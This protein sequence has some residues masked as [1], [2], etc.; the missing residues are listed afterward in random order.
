MDRTLETLLPNSP[1]T[2]EQKHSLE[3]ILDAAA[4]WQAGTCSTGA[5]LE[6]G[7]VPN[8]HGHPSPARSRFVAA[9]L[10]RGD[11]RVKAL[12]ALQDHVTAA[13]FSRSRQGYWYDA[14]DRNLHRIAVMY[15]RNKS[16][17]EREAA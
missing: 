15:L 9:W 6:I 13:T 11:P 4:D 3:D 14:Q 16:D 17:H 10:M 7:L 1:L 2:D 5:V 8:H 12:E